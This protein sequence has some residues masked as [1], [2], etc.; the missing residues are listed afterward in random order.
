MPERETQTPGPTAPQIGT[1]GGRPAGVLPRNAQTWLMVGIA[2]LMI[3]VLALTGGRAPE[4][5]DA[6]PRP[7][8]VAQA[9]ATR[10][11]DYQAQLEAGTAQL[12]ERQ[13]QLDAMQAQAVGGPAVAPSSGRPQQRSAMQQDRERRE[14]E[15]LFAGNIA[16]SH[17]EAVSG[18]PEAAATSP[19]TGADPEGAEPLWWTTLPPVPPWGPG[20]PPALTRPVAPR[21][22]GP[23]YSP[24][25]QY[26]DLPQATGPAYRLFEG[27]F[28]ET[29]L[30]NRLN[31]SFA[32]PINV[33]VS[34]PVYS[35][36]RQ[37]LLIPQGSR[38]L[39]EVARVDEVGQERIAVRFHRLVMP[40]GFTLSLDQF[41]G[42]NQ[43]G[44]TGL[45]D[46]VNHHYLR[47]FGMSIALG[48][49]SGFSLYNS[50]LGFTQSAEDA[51]R[52][53][54]A[55]SLSQSSTRILDRFLNILPTVTIREGHRVMVYLTTD[56]L[57]PAYDAHRMP[58]GL[59]SRAT[60]K[61]PC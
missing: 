10:I 31:A 25:L 17:R 42:L 45:R 22:A 30:T 3:A 23:P 56:L 47:I 6:A 21:A 24:D 5:D 9:S 53:G 43:I 44:E 54:V 60:G 40:D 26:P 37:R 36:D 16:V 1:R 32:G 33:M 61:D 34:T 28:L 49:I 55:R 2:G 46:Q 8:V 20:A 59:S 13:R 58:S 27:T 57:L 12:Q 29:V 4:P 39:G 14:Y 19:I 51:Y 50:S 18:P 35:H 41:Q 11:A 52:G 7:A 38:V 15:S 48:A